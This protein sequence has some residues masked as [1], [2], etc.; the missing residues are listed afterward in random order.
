MND[1]QVEKFIWDEIKKR[2]ITIYDMIGLLGHAVDPT[3]DAEIIDEIRRSRANRF[4]EMCGCDRMKELLCEGKY[5]KYEDDTILK[6]SVND[7]FKFWW[8]RCVDQYLAF[9]EVLEDI[10][11]YFTEQMRSPQKEKEP[12]DMDVNFDQLSL[13][14][15]EHR[16]A[17]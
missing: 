14:E 12:M 1:K 13:F 11:S 15:N 6:I 8:N 17:A 16:K 4:H 5:N 3:P 2:D 7:L 9:D 10:Y